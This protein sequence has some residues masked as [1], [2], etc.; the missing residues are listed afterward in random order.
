MALRP[1]K[2]LGV[3][4]A[5]LLLAGASTLPLLAQTETPPAATQA[6][7]EAPVDVPL[8]GTVS[9]PAAP[10][11]TDPATPPAEAPPTPADLEAV[12]ATISL[13]QERIDALKAEIAEMEGDRT[14][15][16]AA[17]IAAAQRVK[18]A[19]IEVADVEERLSELIVSELEVRG[20]LDGS[21]AE[22]ANVLAA[23]ERISLNPPPAL[24]VDPDDALGSA[25]SAMLIAAIVPQLTARAAA[26]TADLQALT[27]IKAQALAEE[28]TLKA[29]Y[30]VLDEDRLRIATLIAARRQGIDMRSAELAAEEAEA[31]A[32]AAR[33]AT[34]QELIGT[35]SERV[36]SVSTAAAA[37]DAAA[38]PD[39]PTLTPEAIQV[40]LANTARTEPAIP[41]GAARG[42]L[43]MPANGVNV[44]DY[45]A[46]DG[47]GGI[48]QGISVVTRADAQVVAPADGWVLY[49]G[50]YLNYGQI[51]ILNTGQT[52]TV[53]LAGLDTVT[54][55]I[56][57]FV[58]MGMP[59][60]TMGSRTI[61]R[62]VT[63]NA[64][65]DQPTLYIEL[66]Q[67]NEPI[68]PTGWWAAPTQSG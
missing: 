8:R 23:L 32:L 13:T 2:R 11:A 56:G 42:Y 16:N 3:L 12:E 15:Q 20:R 39:A 51:V 19:E 29:N 43:A 31:E 40:A 27:D 65:A 25:R 28:A 52:Y 7:P 44:V 49:K 58:Q 55:D 47:F 35:L 67:N 14:R 9:E 1:G 60:G 5:G 62:S 22:I 18:L 24:I 10:A 68:D 30:D 4:L 17:L 53:L 50:P 63:T 59:L 45:G 61:G 54:V 46:G 66:R 6:P 33:A 34:L 48:S 26:V 38:D 36:T 57:Q 37:A 64:G 41:F 21:N